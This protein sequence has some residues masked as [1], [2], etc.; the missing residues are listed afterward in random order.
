VKILPKEFGGTK[1]TIKEM[2]ENFK[3]IIAE[4]REKLE[5]IDKIEIDE[6]YVKNYGDNESDIQSFRKLEID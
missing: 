2:V 1:M 6:N 5:E 3:K 4:N